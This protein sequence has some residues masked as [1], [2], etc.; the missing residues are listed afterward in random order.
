MRAGV[1]A[2]GI[3]FTAVGC[4]SHGHAAQAS[5]AT[6]S[7]PDPTVLRADQTRVTGTVSAAQVVGIGPP[8]A[9]PFI[10]TVPQRGQGGLSVTGIT[11]AGRRASV[12]WDAGQPLPLSGTGA[13][14]LQQAAL[15]ADVG[16][17]TWHLDGNAR[18]LGAGT[19]TAGSSVAIGTA[20]LAQATDRATFVVSTGGTGQII[21]RG[22]ARVHLAPR[23]VSMTG[24]G[25]V[26]L[27]GKLT[28]QTAAGTRVVHQVTLRSG[29]FELS[30]TPTP[31]GYI[32]TCLLQGAV[33]TA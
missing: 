3:A 32:G 25:S 17:L 27:T 15:D 2:V 21:S 19:Y 11:V 26:T 16:G 5:V 6:P 4:T 20:G 13:L 12:S 10:V 7:A 33:T 14:D 22:D 29:P 30:L 24:P 1:V 9:L 18:L 23:Q 8:L 28:A 31:G